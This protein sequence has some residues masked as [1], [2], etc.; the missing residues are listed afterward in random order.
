MQFGWINLCGAIIVVVM[1]IPNIIYALK[2]QTEETVHNKPMEV[3]EQIGRYG[4]IIFMWLP[5]FV[6]E[7]EFDSVGK[8]LAYV[9]VNGIL[10]LSYLIIWAVYFVKQTRKRAMSLAIIPTIIFMLSGI[11]LNHWALIGTAIL[12]GIG[13]IYVTRSANEQQ[14][15]R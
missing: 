12:F 3:V 7:F 10:I 9:I 11:L 14:S 13:H 8:M 15:K 6:W 4:C 5:L 2:R 1:M